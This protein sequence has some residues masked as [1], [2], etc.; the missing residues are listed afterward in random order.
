MPIPGKR[1]GEETNFDFPYFS[2]AR[3]LDVPRRGA[4]RIFE[5]NR[6]LRF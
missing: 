4:S 2:N 1:A 5:E 3:I 6:F